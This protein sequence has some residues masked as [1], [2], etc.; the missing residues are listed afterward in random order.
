MPKRR[1]DGPPCSVEE[2]GRPVEAKGL[3]LLHYMRVRR[4]GEVGSS[5][6]REVAGKFVTEKG[7]VYVP[8]PD[9]RRWVLEHRLLME[10]HLGRALL[11]HEEVHHKNGIKNDNRLENF[12]LWSRSQPAGAR[13]EDKLAWAIEFLGEY[14]YRVE[15]R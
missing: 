2:C 5:K 4:T 14:G 11:P 8:G 3:C 6:P 15:T 7:Y 12:E 1:P 10:R 9:P 13:V